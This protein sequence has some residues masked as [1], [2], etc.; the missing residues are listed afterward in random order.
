MKESTSILLL[1]TYIIQIVKWYVLIDMMKYCREVF[2]MSKPVICITSKM[3]ECAFKFA[4]KIE[5]EKNQ[6]PRLHQSLT[7]LIETTYVGKLGE[8][9][10]LKYLIDNGVSQDT[11]GM[12]EIFEGQEN[13]DSYDFVQK[14]GKKVDIKTG[15]LSKHKRLMVNASQ[16]KNNPKDI[17]VGV[18]LYTDKGAPN[19]AGEAD[20]NSWTAACIEGY[21]FKNDVVNAGSRNWGKASAN[22][23]YYDKLRNVDDLIRYF[24]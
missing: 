7:V 17:Y 2:N 1:R 10:F 16:L 18:K 5:T 23:I 20:I 9:C 21:A 3:R 15:Y 14:N 4:K 8:I 6:Y 22:A 19:V 24:K 13:V 11:Q 12:F